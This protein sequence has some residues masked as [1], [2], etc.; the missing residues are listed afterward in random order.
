MREQPKV[1]VLYKEEILASLAETQVA[2]G[3][4]SMKV[5]LKSV[6]CYFRDKF[7]TFGVCI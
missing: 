6:S 3:K 5:K 7:T 4:N 1:A 2:S